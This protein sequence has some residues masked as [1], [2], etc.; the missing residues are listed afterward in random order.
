MSGQI[1]GLMVCIGLAWAG[2]VQAQTPEMPEHPRFVFPTRPEV[3]IKMVQPS[4]SRSIGGKLLSL[5][6]REVVIE[7]AKKGPP[8]DRGRGDGGS[9]ISFERIESLRTLDGDFVFTPKEDF[10]AIA[11]RIVATFASV[12]I[13][14]ASLSAGSPPITDT[15]STT[16]PGSDPNEIPATVGHAGTPLAPKIP[17]NNPSVAKPPVK[18][19]GQSGFGGIKSLTKP[20]KTEPA[21]T[22]PPADGSE[23]GGTTEP[24]P[25]PPVDPTAG[26]TEVLLCSNCGKEIPASS[27]RQGVCPH[28]KIAFS[29]V[30]APQSNTAQ[31]PSQKPTGTGNNAFAGT[32]TSPSVAPSVPPTNTGSQVVE[33][34]G[35][36]IDTVPNWAK[37][38]LFV[39]LVLVGW[40]LVM[41]R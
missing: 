6:D 19:L 22:A 11:E 28:C 8:R 35:F 9:S 25:T 18:G 4:T 7:T 13:E 23:P 30:T 37:G 10:H 5:T 26:A 33:N 12:T 14:D 40:H 34:S 2:L 1:A 36:S 31:N 15:P 29:N 17:K 21:S 39:L 41:N 32:S 20:K 3:T 27:A 24:T 16:L 38:G